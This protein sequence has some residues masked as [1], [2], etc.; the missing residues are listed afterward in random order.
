MGIVGGTDVIGR[1]KLSTIRQELE[2]ALIATGDDPIEW[3]ER[4]M[5]APERQGTL[6]TGE[7]TIL[8]SLRRVLERRVSKKRKKRRAS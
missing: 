7:S 3:L 5:A 1:K 2:R 4:R 6:A 8:H